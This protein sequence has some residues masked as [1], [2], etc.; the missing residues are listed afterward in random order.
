MSVPERIGCNVP[1]EAEIRPFVQCAMD[2]GL[3]DLRFTGKY[4]TW[5]N[6]HCEGQ[7]VFSKIDRVLTN[8]EW[9]SLFLESETHFL[10]ENISYHSLAVV[11]FFNMKLGP[12]PFKYFNK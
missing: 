10:P 3:Q 4:Y 6:R 5:N 11:K 2:C 12:R 7:R 1:N 8:Q 9:V